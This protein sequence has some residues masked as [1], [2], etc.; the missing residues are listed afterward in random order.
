MGCA[1]APT[2]LTSSPFCH[3]PLLYVGPGGNGGG[4]HLPGLGFSAPEEFAPMLGPTN[5]SGDSVSSTS[6]R[7]HSRACQKHPSTQDST[8]AENFDKNC[9][10]DSSIV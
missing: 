5:P 9:Q 3:V 8:S 10:S 7:L 4:L 1:V 6:D 2:S